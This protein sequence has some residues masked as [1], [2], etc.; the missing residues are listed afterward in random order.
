MAFFSEEKWLIWADCLASDDFV[1]IDDFFSQE[2]Y[3][4]I[5]AHFIERMNAKKFEKAGIGA[6]ANNTIK[7]EVR[8]DF[9]YWLDKN[10]NP[11][12]AQYFDL[13]DELSLAM[14]RMCFLPVSDSE[15]HYALYPPGTH[16]EAHLDQF[17]SR[18]NR[19]VS[20]VIY[21]NENWK[22]GDGGE[23]KIFKENDDFILIE[24]IAKRCVIFKSERVLHQVM[25]TLMERYS[26]TGWLLKKPLGLGFL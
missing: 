26:L 14:R 19:L 15:F 17:N 21:F 8:G 11:S 10:E 3:L 25:P 24:P 5:R 1:V 20:L 6:L 22:K 23:L 12:I 13:M 4:G 9:T 16:Y 18:S 2:M 7:S